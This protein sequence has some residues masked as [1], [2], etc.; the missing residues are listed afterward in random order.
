MTRT[1]EEITRKFYEV[2]DNYSDDEHEDYWHWVTRN[3]DGEDDHSWELK[4]EY[5]EK[6]QKELEKTVCS[7]ADNS[8]DFAAAFAA[9]ITCVIRYNL[10]DDD[11]SYEDVLSEAAN[12]LVPSGLEDSEDLKQFLKDF[13]KTIC[14]NDYDNIEVFCDYYSIALLYAF[15]YYMVSYCSRNGESP[16][17][18]ESDMEFLKK[19][20]QDMPDDMRKYAL[21]LENYDEKIFNPA[22]PD[23]LFP[24]CYFRSEDKLDID[25]IS[26]WWNI[27]AEKLNISEAVDIIE[28]LIAAKAH[29][30]DYEFQFFWRSFTGILFDRKNGKKYHGNN[31]NIPEITDS[32]ADKN[33]MLHIPAIIPETKSFVYKLL[34]AR[35]DIDNQKDQL[36]KLQ[37]EKNSILNDFSHR[38]KNMSSDVLYDVAQSLMNMESE[39]LQQ[40]GITILQER[41]IKD[42]IKK[43]V[44]LLKLRFTDRTDDL[45]T[46]IRNSVKKNE[47]SVYSVVNV[48]SN[49]IKKCMLTFFYSTD[50]SVEMICDLCFKGR[51]LETVQKNYEQNILFEKNA[52][53]IDWFSRN[54][55][56]INV[57]VSNLWK[58][59]HFEHFGYA[60]IVLIDLFVE[61]IMNV[62]K[63]ADKTKPVYLD[64]TEDNNDF[65]IV[66]RN[67]AIQ[68]KEGIPS[69]SNGIKMQNNL[70]SHLNGKQEAIIYNE[71][72]GIFSI[73]ITIDRRLFLG[74]EKNDQ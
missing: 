63:Y 33:E 15:C 24:F 23:Q 19:L 45:K 51:D 43:E 74:G 62:L 17:A 5:K 28:F 64:F 42:Q 58:T 35:L 55:V 36:V 20:Y 70:I 41:E 29:I 47:K 38:Y 30:D 71:E 57:S 26:T 25:A 27:I 34:D 73:R 54:I 1:I 12:R 39:E 49:S 31:N 37:E 40:Y 60:D 3:I 14:E 56:P 10:C 18:A 66:S 11:E 22:A 69:T 32:I 72:N 9:F 6:M 4:T 68:E 48:L 44:D 21:S 7:F 52:D 46:L 13:S 16:E 50:E 65:I 61:M 67:N 8:D 53:V 59:I 2:I